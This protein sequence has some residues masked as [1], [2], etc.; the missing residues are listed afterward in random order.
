MLNRKTADD[1]T[2]LYVL[3]ITHTPPENPEHAI[4][5][6]L[7]TKQRLG[8]DDARSWIVTTEYNKFTWVGYDVRVLP[9]GGYSYGTL[10]RKLIQQVFTSF[11]QQAVKKAL[12]TVGRNE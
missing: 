1:K 5:L 11:K 7:A 2:V 4:E 12:K 9:S 10:P 8:L 3:P 6:P